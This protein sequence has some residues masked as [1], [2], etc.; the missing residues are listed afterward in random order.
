MYY[1]SWLL[2]PPFLS[3]LKGILNIHFK[4]SLKSTEGLQLQQSQLWSL[5]AMQPAHICQPQWY[6][7]AQNL[8]SRFG[9]P[10]HSACRHRISCSLLSTLISGLSADFCCLSQRGAMEKLWQLQSCALQAIVSVPSC[11][12][13]SKAC[14]HLQSQIPVCFSIR[15]SSVM[16]LCLKILPMV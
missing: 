12:W 11:V 2:H 8:G 13:L 6:I 15:F 9:A 5:C 7:L 1:Y 10:V 3:V 4:S 16:Q 14:K